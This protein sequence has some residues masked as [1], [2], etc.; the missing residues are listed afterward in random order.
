M[1]I[2]KLR[3]SNLNSVYGEW[4]IDF[5]NPVYQSDG[6]FAIT[7][8]TGSGKTTIMDAV[9]LALYGQTPRLGKISQGANEIMSRKTG[10][11]FS[12]VE[13][14]S[15]RGRFKCHWSQKRSYLKPDGNLQA[16]KHE[17]AD[18]STGNI[19]ESSKALVLE[20]V[21]EATGMDFHQFTRSIM[22][23]QG[24]FAAFLEAKPAERAPI[25]EQITGTEIY[26]RISTKVFDKTKEERSVLENLCAGV[27]GISLLSEEEVMK[28]EEERSRK[29]CRSE[30]LLKEIRIYDESLIWLN[31]IKDLRV[32]ILGLKEE[33]NE[34]S[35]E[36]N[37]YSDDFIRLLRA[38]KASELE[39]VYESYKNTSELAEKSKNDYESIV[40]E[41][42]VL[43]RNLSELSEKSTNADKI[44]FDLKERLSDEREIIRRVFEL[45]F[46]INS[47]KKA[48]SEYKK[49]HQAFLE[50]RERHEKNI[51]DLEVLIRNTEDRLKVHSE[52]LKNH[53]KDSELSLN[54]GVIEEK[55]SA[56]CEAEESVKDNKKRLELIESGKN[57]TFLLLEKKQKMLEGKTEELNEAEAGCSEIYEELSHVLNGK[58]IEAIRSETD[59]IQDNIRSLQRL[60]ELSTRQKQYISD[61][62]FVFRENIRINSEAEK[63]DAQIIILESEIKTEERFFREL[64]DKKILL[65]RIKNLEEQREE[66]E[67]GKPC[68][69]CGSLKHP[70][71][72]GIITNTGD[73][74]SQINRQ[75][76]KIILLNDSLLQKKTELAKL[77]E[78][79]D[80]NL[81]KTADI[82]KELIYLDSEIT[83][84][85]EKTELKHDYFTKPDYFIN[86]ETALCRDHMISKDLLKR[87][88]DKKQILEEAV[89]SHTYKK[90]ALHEAEKDYNLIKSQYDSLINDESK[91][92]SDI[93]QQTEKLE[94]NLNHLTNILKKF[95]ETADSKVRPEYLPIIFKRLIRRKEEYSE[96]KSKNDEISDS[97][98][99]L[100]NDVR[101]EEKSRSDA[102]SEIT[103]ISGMLTASEDTLKE[104][105]S[106]RYLLYKEKDPKTEE[107]ILKNLVSE[108]ESEAERLKGLRKSTE[109]SLK[110]K[111]WQKDSLETE[112]TRYASTLMSKE[113]VF[114]EKLSDAGF[115]D[116]K[117]FTDSL[118]PPE[119]ISHLNSLKEEV[120][121]RK[122]RTE[123]MLSDRE[124]SLENEI[125]KHLTEKTESVLI[126]EKESLESENSTLLG[127]IGG[128][129]SRF[130][131]NETQKFRQK[132][133]LQKIENQKEVCRRWDNL[134]ALIGSKDGKKFRNFAQGLTFEIMIANAN[135]Q[136]ERMSDRYILMHSPD[137]PLELC[138]IDNY[139]AG[140]IRSTRNLSGGESFIVSLALALGL[141]NMASKN[142][143]VDSLFLDE[144]FGTL[145]EDALETA[146][147]TLAGLRQDGKLIGIISHVLAIRERIPAKIE[148]VKRSGG[149]SIIKGPGC[150]K[151]T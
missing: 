40:K 11:C 59:A 72:S 68:P 76:Q 39:G 147:E 106:Q 133:K 46:K 85:I 78:R 149:K 70:Y 137:V 110:S 121:D 28:L 34:I 71:S 120:F 112:K 109:G 30:E 22:L 53:Q 132:E 49:R 8:P 83:T 89:K 48:F 129:D 150:T 44:L 2:L 96:N 86:A 7:G 143:R 13:F 84:E 82:E 65:L 97:L 123:A 107:D 128:I 64:E 69:L 12:E 135:R 26:S 10:E 131:D 141:S 73:N 60:N 27:E 125:K 19:L 90:D 87:A 42:E 29:K 57:E 56:F 35:E 126:E 101:S 21:E 144:G 102:E 145:D 114:S 119:D 142:V 38:K 4:I 20:R 54:I 5:T 146:L 15:S 104:Y 74:E 136:L 17:I 37:K 118:L 94:R 88:E 51:R 67:D 58:T 81:I 127:E 75:R 41:T 1:K 25:L 124:K 99:N 36:I 66:L 91:L 148:V 98:K 95:D 63:I 62:N 3:F 33:K 151:K 45:D 43:N 79:I 24:G 16:P 50:K 115:L 134:S 117:E 139:Q 14:E 100:I 103:D 23:A 105:L 92:I 18:A 138:V 52:Y 77:K 61:K 130:K 113:M 32:G 93:S 122:K 108:A 47:E 55:I 9:C 80:Q 140:E 31:K 6:I 111:L 116:I